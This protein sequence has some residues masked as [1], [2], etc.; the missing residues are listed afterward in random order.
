LNQTGEL[1]EPYWFR[2][3]RRELV[4]EALGVVVRGEVAPLAAPVGQR[5]GDAIDELADAGLR[6]GVLISP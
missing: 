6:S 5:P 2:Q 1:N 3:R 4:V